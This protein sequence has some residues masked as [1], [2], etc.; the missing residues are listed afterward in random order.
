[1]DFSNIRLPIISN[2]TIMKLRKVNRSIVNNAGGANGWHPKSVLP[3]MT[4]KTFVWDNNPSHC[5]WSCEKSVAKHKYLETDASDLE[6]LGAD[7]A[8][9]T[10]EGEFFGYGAYDQWMDLVSVFKDHGPGT[11]SHPIFKDIQFAILKKLEAKAEPRQDYVAYTFE[12]WEYREP[13][14]ILVKLDTPVS[15]STPASIPSDVT[16]T[17]K[18]TYT[19]LSGDTL[20]GISKKFC[21]DGSRYTEI[22][23]AN[24]IKNPNIISVGQVLTIPF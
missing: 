6:D 1:V 12:F 4:Y 13:K 18:K 5:T 21:G 14:E 8:V 19:V 24:N 17:V 16:T 3:S 23:T 9:L 20:W 22:A 10:G 2:E 7:M 11:F 15:P